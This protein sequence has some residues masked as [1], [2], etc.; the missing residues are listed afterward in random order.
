MMDKGQLSLATCLEILM[1]AWFDFVIHLLFYI[2]KHFF[3]S[4]ALYV[5]FIVLIKQSY[6]F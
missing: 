6:I 5:N 2:P 3:L 1:L 4:G